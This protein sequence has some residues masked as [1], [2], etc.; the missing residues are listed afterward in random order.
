MYTPQQQCYY[1]KHHKMLNDG[2][3]GDMKC[4]GNGNIRVKNTL[5]F[6]K[7]DPNT[8]FNPKF[9]ESHCDRYRKI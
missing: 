7:F 3:I 9:V 8:R 1:C 4:N 2:D 5:S 6:V